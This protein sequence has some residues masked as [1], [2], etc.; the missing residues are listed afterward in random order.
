M[1][2]P[3]LFNV[4]IQV[5]TRLLRAHLGTNF[6]ISINYRKYRSLFDLKKLKAHTKISRAGFLE[7]QYADDCALVTHSAEDLQAALSQVLLLYAKLGLGINVQK[8]EVLH[9]VEGEA[10][11]I[12]LEGVL[13]KEVS[14]FKYLGSHVSNNCRTDDEIHSRVGKASSAFGRLRGRVF[15]NHSL[16]LGTKIQVYHAVVLSALLYCSEV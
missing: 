2:A 4:Y 15:S 14:S 8:T 1:L 11:P 7:L 9:F 16:K 3:V 6:G 12:I 10:P 5:V 13:L